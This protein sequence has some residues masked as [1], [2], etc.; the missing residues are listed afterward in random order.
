MV[1]FTFFNRSIKALLID[2]SEYQFCYDSSIEG[3]ATPFHD[4][5]PLNSQKLVVKQIFLC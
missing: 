4:F 2:L 5:D 3:L 1:F